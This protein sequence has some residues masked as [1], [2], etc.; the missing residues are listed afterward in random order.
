MKKLIMIA[1][2]GIVLLSACKK[3]KNVTPVDTNPRILSLN[4]PSHSSGL[5]VKVNGVQVSPPLNVYK[6]DAVYVYRDPGGSTVYGGGSS[7]NWNVMKVYIDGVIID[8]QSCYCVY[9]Y[10]FTVN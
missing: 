1:L 6:N 7:Y 9:Q 2:T 4:I 10:S 8:Q 5:T 3:E